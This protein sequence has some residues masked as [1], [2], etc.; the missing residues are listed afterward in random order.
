MKYKKIFALIVSLVLIWIF[1]AVGFA[2][3]SPTV[4]ISD[5]NAKPGDAVFIPIQIKDNPGIMGF[6]ITLKYDPKILTPR[7]VSKGT[8]TQAGMFEDSVSSSD[9]GSFDIVWNNVKE[10][11]DDGTLA[12][13]GFTCSGK[14]ADQ[15]EIEISYSQDDTFNE[16]YE[17]VVFECKNGLIDFT[18]TAAESERTDKREVTPEDIVIAVETVQ[19]DPQITPTNAVME[20]VNSLLSQI[21]GNP[22]PYFSSPDE[23]TASYTQA[24]KETF[25]KDVLNTVD[26]TKVAEVI[27]NAL[28]LTGADSVENVPEDMRVDF[29][30]NIETGLKKEMPDIK[31][32]SDYIS[33]EDEIPAIAQLLEGANEEIEKSNSAI[34]KITASASRNP[35]IWAACIA[36]GVILIAM[37]ILLIIKSAKKKA[38]KANNK[39]KK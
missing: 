10:I 6:R 35:A 24:V 4:Y 5:F 29:I 22:E 15:T 39:G 33:Q 19:G 7:A 1:S 8:V 3:K 21:T 16:K 31:E 23:I 11:K 25:V 37:I 13:A 34:G 36:G 30:N 20:S 18:G 26:E 28:S 12:V 38:T 32:L 14:A 27:Q 17:N 2:S 9:K